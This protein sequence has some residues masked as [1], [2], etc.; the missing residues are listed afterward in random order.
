MLA[1]GTLLASCRPES[2][3]AANKAAITADSSTGFLVADTIIYDVMIR[4]PDPDDLWKTKC[5]Q[6][7]DRQAFIDHVFRMLYEEQAIAYDFE[8]R[9]KI[10]PAMLKNLE[11]DGFN[12]DHIGMIQFTEAWYLDPAENRMT[13]NVLSLVLGYDYYT[14]EGELFGHKPLFRVELGE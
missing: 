11:S 1:A 6:G 5:L 2:P 10:T 7:L 3:R 4:N 8:T 14:D 9:E 12:R 13:K